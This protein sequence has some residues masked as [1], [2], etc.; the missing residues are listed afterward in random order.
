MQV[1]T[2]FA[3]NNIALS[4]APTLATS[5]EGHLSMVTVLLTGG[6]L[7]ARL[8]PVLLPARHLSAR[9]VAVGALS[10]LLA[11]QCPVASRPSAKDASA[12]GNRLG[13]WRRLEHLVVRVHCLNRLAVDGRFQ[14][15]R[16]PHLAGYVNWAEGYVNLSGNCHPR[17]WE[18]QWL[19]SP[20]SCRAAAMSSDHWH[21]W[22]AYGGLLLHGSLP[23]WWQS[24][25]PL[26]ED[27]HHKCPADHHQR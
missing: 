20:V 8:V 18:H 22:P 27:P 4:A 11:R 2:K 21:P 15:E 7:S 26:L 5:V 1:G 14:A 12:S 23:A 9:L 24:S 10:Y 25:L 17:C 13:N 19:Q 6:H 16:H 3:G